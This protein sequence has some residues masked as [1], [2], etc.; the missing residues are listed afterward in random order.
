MNGI[1]HIG[2]E[3]TGTTTIQQFLHLNRGHLLSQKT[4]FLHSPG[5]RNDRKLAVYCMEDDVVD[6]YV[7]KN[8]IVSREERDQWRKEFDHAFKEE[9]IE[10][11]DEVETVIFSSEHFHSRLQSVDSIKRLRIFLEPY[12][13]GFKIIV[14][15]R[16]QDQLAISHYST[17]CKSGW[18][19]MSLLD[20]AIPADS[21]YYNYYKLIER[22]A[23][24]FG[25]GNII[26]RIFE[27]GNFVDEDLI[28]DFLHSCNLEHRNDFVLPKRLNEKLSSQVQHAM[29]LFN[30]CFPPY[31]G[32]TS[33][34]FNNRLREYIYNNLSKNN[35]GKES[36][37][38][39]SEAI[40]FYSKF[41]DSNDKLAKKY[42][43]SSK[44]FSADFS[45]YP[46]VNQNV[47]IP[48]KLVRDML[49]LISSFIADSSRKNSLQLEFNDPGIT[50]REIALDYESDQPEVALFLLKEAKKYRPKGPM[51]IRKIKQLEDKIKNSS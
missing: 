27:K 28:K 7:K 41:K 25:K 39:I 3:K 34:P 21:P 37:P 50:L 16:R 1:L 44:L 42:L 32:N 18:T 10:L 47:S 36:M 40:K 33:I 12:F 23:D 6:D 26:I 2:T 29:V 31:R 24:V 4:A 22:W 45:M 17:M 11:N 8:C 35:Q 48:D 9:M 5:E 51:I 14:Y 46:E 15:L 43:S 20:Q 19:K 30:S 13:S 38:T 49:R